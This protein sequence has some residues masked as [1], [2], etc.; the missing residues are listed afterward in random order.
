MNQGMLDRQIDCIAALP[1]RLRNIMEMIVVD[2]GSPDAPQP[3]FRSPGCPL[4]IYRIGIDIKWNQDAARNIAAHEARARWLL[5][6]DIDHLV[7]HNTWAALESMKLQ[8]EYVYKFGKR[9]T[10]EA[11]GPKPK[12]TEYKPHPNSWLMT[13]GMYWRIGGY[14]ERFAGNYGTDADFRDRIAAKVSI[15]PLALDIWRVPRE[16]IPDASTRTLK[17]KDPAEGNEIRRIKNMR[18]MLED[19]SPLVLQY[20][21]NLVGQC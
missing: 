12:V 2:D 11:D 5:L 7:P 18:A 6:T 9:M 15:V 10:L 20:P 21:Y 17:R 19:Q 8:K 16:T 13:R 14:D 4:R 1:K 3:S